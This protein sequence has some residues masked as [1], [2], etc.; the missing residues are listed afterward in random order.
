MPFYLQP[1]PGSSP[2]PVRTARN[3]AWNYAGY[4][5]QIA[6]NLGLTWYIVRKVS[7]VEY[8]LFLFVM[9]LASTLYL[10]D[11][12]ISSVLI[13]VFVEAFT[14]AGKERVNEILGTAFLALTALGSLGVLIFCS[15]ALSLPGPFKI[16]PAYLHEAFLIFILAGFIILVGFPAIAVE[17]VFQASHRFDRTNQVQLVAGVLLIALSVLA[18]A[19]GHGIVALALV[20]LVAALFR[21]L[22]LVLALPATLPGIRLSFARFNPARLKPL[23]HLSKWAFLNNLSAS[24]FDMLIWVILG[25]L[26]SMQAAALF[27]LANKPAKQLWN[28]VDRGAS[29]TFPLLSR[30]FA[31]KD[32]SGL[33]QTYLRTMKL[34]FGAVLPFIVLGCVFARPLILVWAGRQYE[35]AALVMEWLLLAALSQALTYPS[36]LVLYACGMVKKAAWI[37]LVSSAA[38]LI[39]AALLVFRY[40]AAGM[41]AGMAVT[42]LVFNCGLFTFAACRA[43]GTSPSVLLRNL[44]EGMPWPIAVLAAEIS[45]SL[46]LWPH[47]S[48]LGLVVIAFT[49][50]LIYLAL[51][52][53]RTALPIY[54]GYTEVVPS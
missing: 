27:G 4:V 50:G 1:E 29:V 34:V 22:L 11:I 44:F 36:D 54:R 2:P 24:L 25:S 19:T 13:Q 14:G 20:Q 47:L 37:S 23:F 53:R 26:G 17:Q 32:S 49:A 9:A 21:L 12:G 16:P 6:I 51:W 35:G 41:A 30:S 8:G 46:A 15:L 45:V 10:L 38:S 7:V 5:C 28:L 43:T 31:E 39:A 48:P 18:L 42:Q 33:R 52:A 3:V 40:G